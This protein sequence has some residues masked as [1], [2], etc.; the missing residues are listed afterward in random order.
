ML[1]NPIV[2]I[3]TGI[4]IVSVSVYADWGLESWYWFQRSGSLLV[5]LG[6]L[7]E[8]RSILRLGV[9]GV[10]GTNTSILKGKV[11]NIDN[12]SEVQK[13]GIA[14]DE[15]TTNYLYQ[16]ALDKISGYVGAIFLIF[17]TI[18]WGY[19]DLAGKVIK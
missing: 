5:L 14:Y 12:S 6:A 9:K 19:G 15:E 13:V 7:M 10:G 17:G 8:I 18:I 3:I 4:I 1:K 2:L 11:V 16:A